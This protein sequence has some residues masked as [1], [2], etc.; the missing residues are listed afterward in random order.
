MPKNEKV[1]GQ[2]EVIFIPASMKSVGHITT[3]SLT[4]E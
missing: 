3:H 1:W 2:W 4:N